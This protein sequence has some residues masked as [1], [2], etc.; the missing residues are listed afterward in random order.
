MRGLARRGLLASAVGLLAAAA[1]VLPAAAVTRPTPPIINDVLLARAGGTGAVYAIAAS[2]CTA[3]CVTLTRVTDGGLHLTRVTAPGIA[4]VSGES[5]GDLQSM[6]F[7][8]VD[9]GIVLLGPPASAPGGEV[10]TNGAASWSKVAFGNGLSILSL[11]ATPT[12][13]YAVAA[14][15]PHASLGCTGARLLRSP[16][17]SIDWSTVALANSAG[18]GTFGA[19]VTAAG[20]DVWIAEA[21]TNGSPR[22]ATSHDGG[23][24]FSLR[25][26]PPLS[27]VDTCAITA[28]S[29]TS[30][31]AR[32][33]TGM[34]VSFLHSTDGGAAW[35]SIP[36]GI[37]SNTGG[38][39]FDPVQ[40]DLATFA[41]GGPGD[42]LETVTG[43]TKVTR[44]HHV[45]LALVSGLVFT[46]PETGLA[47]GT[48][49][50]GA[51]K[52]FLSRT[53]DGGH[54]WHVVDLI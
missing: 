48:P 17:S 6:V 24:T 16:T 25:A 8:N 23:T 12:E 13:Y 35:H 21:T 46:A 38:S 18:I 34:L 44:V 4:P 3:T 51:D 22:L 2:A 10:T 7:A 31:W 30:L 53:A 40:G 26:E 39:W 43:G 28:T 15:C 11:T 47:A 20:G 1:V 33:P 32:C 36:L 50:P 42:E 29:A 5:T 45:P 9:D 14:R 54:S 19:S 52:M 37:T 27:A 41:S 49:S